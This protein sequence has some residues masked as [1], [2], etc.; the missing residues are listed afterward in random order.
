MGKVGNVKKKSQ[1]WPGECR[2]GHQLKP[3]FPELSGKAVLDLG[4]GYGWH[5]SVYMFDI[6]QAL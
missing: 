5:L 4:C 3:M 1:A 2:G 6:V